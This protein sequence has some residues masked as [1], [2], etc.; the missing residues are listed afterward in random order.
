MLSVIFA[1][2]IVINFFVAYWDNR[3]SDWVTNKAAIAEHYVLKT[4]WFF[5]DLMSVFPWDAIFRGLLGADSKYISLLRLIRLVRPPSISA[6][7]VLYMLGL[8][9]K[10]RGRVTCPQAQG[11]MGYLAP[12][13]PCAPASL[14][15]SLEFRESRCG[16][17]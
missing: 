1:V 17:K 10:F 6:L 7:P 12:P 9:C 13:P 16:L 4:P 14:L 15:P 11:P 5:I 3:E 2:D 8:K